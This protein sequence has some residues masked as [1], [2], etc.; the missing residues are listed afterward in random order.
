M[1]KHRLQHSKAYQHQ[2]PVRLHGDTTACGHRSPAQTHTLES[3]L[4][5][6]LRTAGVASNTQSLSATCP[7][8][9]ARRYHSLRSSQPSANAHSRVVLNHHSAHCRCRIQRSKAYQQQTPV[10]LH[11]DA[12][13]CDHRSLAQ[14]HTLES[15]STIT[16]HTAGVASNAQKHISSR[17]P[18]DYMAM[19]QP[20]VIAG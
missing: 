20:A 16:L 4:A 17:P 9:T 18:S 14:T 5:I 11:G 1:L 6:T 7:R 13:A 12:T 2:A 19:P 3:S 10:R 15:S 8:P